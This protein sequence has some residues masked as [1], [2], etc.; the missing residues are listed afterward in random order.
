[1]RETECIKQIKKENREYKKIKF[2]SW[3]KMKL[4]FSNEKRKKKEFSYSIFQREKFYDNKANALPEDLYFK[5]T[6]I[7]LYDL[8]QK[9]DLEIVKKG[10]GR[11]FKKCLSPTEIIYCLF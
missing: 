10:L 1:M 6:D 5:P 4:T 9:Q 3:I 11:L 2:L 8:I 7:V